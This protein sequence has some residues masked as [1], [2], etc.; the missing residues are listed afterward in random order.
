MQ[1]A[2]VRN[3]R[4]VW[5]VCRFVAIAA[6]AILPTIAAGCAARYVVSPPQQLLDVV[7]PEASVTRHVVIVSID[8]LRPDAITALESPTLYRLMMEGSYS[9][10]ASTIMP[11][12][13]LPSHTSMLTGEPPERHGV[14]WNNTPAAHF[15]TIEVPTIFSVARSRGYRTAAFFSKS[16]FNTLQRPGTL[17]YSQA[18]GGW[19]GR[20]SS[21]RTVGDVE[22]H[23]ASAR[24]NILFVHVSDPDYA[25]HEFEWMSAEYRRAVTAAD[26]ALARVLSAAE[27]AYGA[28][29][30][31]VIVT[32][33][34]GGHGHDHGTDDP[35][36]V[37]IPW[38]VWGRG[39][40]PGG[41]LAGSSIRTMD[42]ASTVLWLLGLPEPTD[43]IGTPV[44]AAFQPQAVPAPALPASP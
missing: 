14:F 29:N 30:Y 43:W 42:T 8:G 16:K 41:E 19:F 15:D 21:D 23:L 7:L 44:L 31:S 26:G 32:A 4:R 22:R 27:R 18:P 40:R 34:H 10:A 5:I 24:P 3:Q 33:D 12:K 1:S 36:D 20:W 2:N 13:T 39:V 6:V 35:R 25:G 17:D 37:T 38:I 28:G 9:L 11:S